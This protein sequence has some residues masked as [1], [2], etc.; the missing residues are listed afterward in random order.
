MKTNYI[1]KLYDALQKGE[2]V[3]R[4]KFCREN[5]ISLRT[6]Y[7]YIDDIR[8]FLQTEKGVCSLQKIKSDSCYRIQSDYG[9]LQKPVETSCDFGQSI[10]CSECACTGEDNRD[11]AVSL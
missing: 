2:I 7:R 9:N 3:S 1:L 6:F 5:Q 4:E 8:Y 10:M 11:A